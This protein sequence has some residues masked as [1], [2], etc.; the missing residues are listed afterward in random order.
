MSQP[1][2]QARFTGAPYSTSVLFAAS[3]ASYADFGASSRPNK[4]VV[5]ATAAVDVLV[6]PSDSSGATPAALPT[7]AAPGPAPVAG[8]LRRLAANDPQEF[9]MGTP[10]RYWHFRVSGAC[11][12]HVAGGLA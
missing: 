7:A 11:T 9:S 3:G 12:L 1:I 10:G 6:L 2:S 5:T 4:V 8:E